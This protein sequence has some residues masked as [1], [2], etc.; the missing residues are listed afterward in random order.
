MSTE[1]YTKGKYFEKHPTWHTEDSYFKA[2]QIINT[3]DRN[4]LK[5]NSICEVGC[6]AGEIL[7]QLY[8][9]MSNDVSFVGYEISPQAY[10]LC[11]PKKKGR[12]Q[13]HLKDILQDDNAFFDL[14]LVMDVIEH[15]E[16]YYNFLR[17][18]QK[19]GQ[20]KMFRIPLD[21]SVK[22]IFQR[23]A[24][25]LRERETVGH[26]HYFT[27]EI[28][29]AALK[30]TGY[31][32]LDYFYTPLITYLRNRSLKIKL[33]RLPINIM[34]KLCEDATV[35]IFGGYSLIVLAK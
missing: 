17:K 34:F 16:D 12:L 27:K 10:K 18:L 13:Y 6:G 8:A 1:M 15:I 21:I 3:I 26:I 33:E 31:E 19:R 23:C 24:H 4:K 28:A 2:R 29:F 35:R 7:N 11:W 20:Y 9:Q 25:I 14:V 32:V 30:D 22:T 5:P